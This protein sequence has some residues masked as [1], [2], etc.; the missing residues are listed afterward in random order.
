MLGYI[1][2]PR[3]NMANATTDRYLLFPKTKY[4]PEKGGAVDD[5]G[6]VMNIFIK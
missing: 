1:T 5:R 2:T 6:M 4:P 3:S